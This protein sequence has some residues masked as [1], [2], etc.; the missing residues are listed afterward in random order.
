MR[1]KRIAVDFER[2]MRIGKKLMSVIRKKSKSPLEGYLVVKM[3]CIYFEDNKGL[4]LD[5]ASE[6]KLRSIARGAKCA[7]VSD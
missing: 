6:K 2:I 3:L 4:R 1:T 5:D 7:R